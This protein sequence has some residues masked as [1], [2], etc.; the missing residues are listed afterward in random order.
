[1][2]V[3][4]PTPK[5]LPPEAQPLPG[6]EEPFFD[7]PTVTRRLAV[8]DPFIDVFGKP[9]SSV[10]TRPGALLETILD[11]ADDL[12]DDDWPDMFRAAQDWNE[13]LK[14]EGST[15]WPGFPSQNP[16]L[17]A[18]DGQPIVYIN[19]PERQLHVRTVNPSRDFIPEDD[20]GTGGEAYRTPSAFFAAGV[21]PVAAAIAAEV[22]LTTGLTVEII[23]ALYR[24]AG[25]E[26]PTGL[27]T[28]GNVMMVTGGI[29]SISTLLRLLGEGA[30]IVGATKITWMGL[31]FTLGAGIA[32]WG[33]LKTDWVEVWELIGDCVDAGGRRWDCTVEV[34]GDVVGKWYKDAGKVFFTTLVEVAEPVA[35]AVGKGFAPFLIVGGAALVLVMAAKQKVGL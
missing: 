4:K 12:T 31:L 7:D 29:L 13:L 26:P 2:P 11:L 27:E 20:P 24:F 22:M 25:V 19:W 30:S 8:R 28:F 17:T 16:R 9:P 6:F 33:F 23:L 32:I 18:T 5:P 35:K 1:V 14:Q 10:L 34:V 3:A 15:P 21:I